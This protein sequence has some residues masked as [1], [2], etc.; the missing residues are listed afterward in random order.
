MAQL[1]ILIEMLPLP[2]VPPNLKIGDE[3]DRGAWGAVHKGELD[4]ELVAVKNVHQLLKDAEGGENTVR[5]FFDEC[6]RLRTINHKHVISEW[7]SVYIATE[8]RTLWLY[9]CIYIYIYI[10]IIVS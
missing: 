4:G 6:E 9:I 2:I 3:I 10:Y 1:R 7:R 5:S 8:Q